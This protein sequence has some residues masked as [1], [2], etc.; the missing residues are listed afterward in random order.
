MRRAGAIEFSPELPAWKQKAIDTTMMGTLEK[1]FLEFNHTWWPAYDAFWR[2]KNDEQF[3]KST[4]TEFY[5]LAQLKVGGDHPSVLLATP[6]GARVG[7][8]VCDT[9]FA[10]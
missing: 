8:D 10:A 7:W 4:A 6:A 5:N 2:V 3:D 1:V 9:G